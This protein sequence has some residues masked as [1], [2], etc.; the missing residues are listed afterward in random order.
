RVGR[1]ARCVLSTG[2]IHSS[3]PRRRDICRIRRGAVSARAPLWAARL[4]GRCFHYLRRGTLDRGHPDA[5]YVPRE[6]AATDAAPAAHGLLSVRVRRGNRIV[7]LAEA[8]RLD[9]A[10]HDRPLGSPTPAHAAL[11]PHGLLPPP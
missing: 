2:S 3:T 4:L 1:V 9:R 6:L 8:R 7:V 5:D 11:A 10:G